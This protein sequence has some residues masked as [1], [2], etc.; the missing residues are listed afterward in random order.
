MRRKTTFA[1][2]I[3]GFARF[4]VERAKKD[5]DEKIRA[6]KEKERSKRLKDSIDVE[7]RIIKEE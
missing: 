5:L 4:L 7:Y 1:D 3:L 2:I 6:Q